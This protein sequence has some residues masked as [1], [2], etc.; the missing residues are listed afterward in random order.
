MSNPWEFLD[1]W[2]RKHVHAVASAFGRSLK[3]SVSPM[4]MSSTAFQSRIAAVASK[5]VLFVTRSGF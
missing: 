5:S 3:T 2:A 1:G 4:R